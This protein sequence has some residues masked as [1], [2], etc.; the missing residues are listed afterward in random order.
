[1]DDY[2]DFITKYRSKYVKIGMEVDLDKNGDLTILDKHKDSWD[3]MIGAVHFFPEC[4]KDDMK[5]GFIWAVEGY[6]NSDIDILAVR[7][8]H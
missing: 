6:A 2:I 3:L 4:F 8:E 5:S 7:S 1:M